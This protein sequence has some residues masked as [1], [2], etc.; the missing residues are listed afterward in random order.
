MDLDLAFTLAKT[1][2]G[3]YNFLIAF[4]KFEPLGVAC[5]YNGAKGSDTN[6]FSDVCFVLLRLQ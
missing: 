3:V 2:F 1:L 6:K 4:Y 5:V